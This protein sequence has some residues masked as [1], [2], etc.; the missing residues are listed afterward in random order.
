MNFWEG[1]DLIGKL[2]LVGL[3]VYA[4]KGSV[5]QVAVSSLL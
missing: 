1:I 4:G 5:L 2:W 3:V